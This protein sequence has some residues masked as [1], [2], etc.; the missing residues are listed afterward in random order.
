MSPGEPGGVTAD[1]IRASDVD[2]E[3]VVANLA[4]IRSTIEATGRDPDSVRIVAVTKGQPAT[5]VSAAL[6]AGLCDIGENYA[7]ELVSKAEAFN[8][9]TATLSEGTLSEHALRWH[10][11][12]RLQ[13]NKI[14]RLVPHVWLWQTVDS[15]ARGHALA[16]RAPGAKVLVQVDFSSDPGR[17]GVAPAQVSTVVAECRDVGLEVLGLMCVAPFPGDGASS[18]APTPDVVFAQ[19]SHVADELG[20]EHRSMGMSDDFEAAVRAGSTIIRIGSALFGA[21]PQKESA[22]G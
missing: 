22:L 2:I 8:N 20:L 19:L 16:A 14:N 1:V 6:S 15:T 21:R 10:F 5:M 9:S 4:T 7:D 18:L 11:Q 13:T 12:G 3:R 17:G